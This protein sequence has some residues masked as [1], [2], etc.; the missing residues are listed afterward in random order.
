MRP[1][2]KS[3]K[4]TESSTPAIDDV[5]DQTLLTLISS[6]D[7]DAFT[8]LY[9]KY[10]P[11]LLYYCTRVLKGDVALAA[12]IVDD[13][14]F[15][16]WRSAG[17]FEGK[18]KAST[19]IHS[20]A[21]NKLVSYLRKNSDSRLDKDLLQISLEDSNVATPDELIQDED[22]NAVLVRHM[23]SLSAEHREIL[24]LAYFRELPVK[25]IANMLKISENTVK[26]RMFHARKRMRHI[27]TRAGI[28]RDRND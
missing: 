7:R 15:D 25:T 27:L 20:I 8:V 3:K 13:A 1:F 19:W 26:T 11:R 24:E 16:V 17:K 2:K 5:D 4:Q 14:L 9:R 10:Q 18:S 12:D 6:G 28:M 23:G 21:H 22:L